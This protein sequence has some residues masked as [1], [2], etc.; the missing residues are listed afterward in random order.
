MPLGHVTRLS[1][2]RRSHAPHTRLIHRSFTIEVRFESTHFLPANSPSHPCQGKSSYVQ[3]SD[4]P[5]ATDRAFHTSRN[6]GAVGSRFGTD[7]QG[8]RTPS[9][10][11]LR[12]R[13]RIRTADRTT[14]C[15]RPWRPC[16]R[17]AAG[18]HQGLAADVSRYSPLATILWPASSGQ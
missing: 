12:G 11:G 1:P 6:G 4:H 8:N 9:R 13:R 15:G 7:V 5:H 18:D 3:Q 16:R 2:H 10:G 14:S 17:P